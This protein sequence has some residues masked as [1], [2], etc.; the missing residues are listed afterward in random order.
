MDYY[1]SLF[2][3]CGRRGRKNVSTVQCNACKDNVT[4]A[5]NVFFDHCDICKVPAQIYKVLK[6]EERTC[7]FL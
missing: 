2:I 5:A 3:S 1:C 6:T 7:I 4:K